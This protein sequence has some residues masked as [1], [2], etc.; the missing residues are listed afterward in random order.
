MMSRMFGRCCAPEAAAAAAPANHWRLVQVF[1][2]TASGAHI[3]SF[4]SDETCHRLLEVIRLALR[5]TMERLLL[6]DG[7][8]P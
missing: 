6:Y 7:V 3:I 4:E 8:H 1:I 2:F 5:D